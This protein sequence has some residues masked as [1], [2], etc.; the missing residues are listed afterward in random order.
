[1]TRLRTT[2][3]WC[4]L[5]GVGSALLLSL[6]GATAI[7]PPL[8]SLVEH[9]GVS[10]LLAT[11][12][13][14]L[15][16][17]V[18]LMLLALS[19]RNSREAASLAAAKP[20]GPGHARTE[21]HEALKQVRLMSGRVEPSQIESLVGGRSAVR[22]ARAETPYVVIRA[23]VWA[24]PALGFIGTAAEMS[25]SI[26]GLSGA[27]RGTSSYAELSGV[28]VSDVIRPLASAFGI[29][30]FAL[31]SSVVFHLLVS[32]VHTREER[33]LLELDELVLE[34]LSSAAGSGAV[35][36]RDRTAE[37]EAAAAMSQ[38][39]RSAAEEIQGLNTEVGRLATEA[40]RV[41]FDARDAKPDRAE[42]VIRQLGAIGAQLAAI[43]E[44]LDR[45][46][47]LMPVRGQGRVP[48]QGGYPGGHGPAGGP[49]G[50]GGPGDGVL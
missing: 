29:T 2:F 1:M 10:Q 44:G 5:L 40:S 26:R 32:F 46:M 30:L 22:G 18:L 35:S 14:A 48:G 25:R 33:L 42:E 12:V 8:H 41:R 7:V 50:P 43:G 16:I 28:L 27:M 9:G 31:G 34:R 37:A 11:S 3:I 39:M 13:L 23:L 4:G 24:L 49:G 19:G 20:R 45:E 36:G 47:V 21:V 15:N 38:A 17:W 6:T